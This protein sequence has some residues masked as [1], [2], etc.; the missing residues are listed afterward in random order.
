[1]SALFSG[2]SVINV[3]MAADGRTLVNT[4]DPGTADKPTAVPTP[5][6]FM[7]VKDDN[8]VFGQASK[9]LK[10]TAR[11]GDIIRWRGTSLSLNGDYNIFLYAFFS[12]KGGDLLSTPVDL[13]SEITRPLPNPQDPAVP[14]TQTVKDV[15]WQSTVLTKGEVTYAF[16][17]MVNDRNGTPLG[18][19]YWDPFI[20]ITE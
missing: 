9:E 7:M 12:L 16:R 19:Y 5:S 10:L 6:I 4:L 15:F 2:P 8:A 3:L 1:M 20:Q 17:F 11:T 14:K 18:Y 13:T